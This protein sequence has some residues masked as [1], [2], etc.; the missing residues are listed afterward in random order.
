MSLTCL[1]SFFLRLVKKENHKLED[2]TFYKRSKEHI[3]LLKLCKEINEIFFEN[4]LCIWGTSFKEYS[5]LK[6]STEV[7]IHSPSDDNNTED[8]G[9]VLSGCF[10]TSKTKTYEKILNEIKKKYDI[11]LRVNCEETVSGNYVYIEPFRHVR[12]I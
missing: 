2:D 12:T 8:E 6:V 7:I 3:R 10:S 9:L 5:S 11:D 4:D 1:L